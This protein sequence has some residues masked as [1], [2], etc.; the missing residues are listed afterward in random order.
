[1]PPAKKRA[2]SSRP[3][4]PTKAERLQQAKDRRALRWR[5][6]AIVLLVAAL[7]AYLLAN[8]TTPDDRVIAA[9]E[10]SEACEYDTVTD[11]DPP[12]A[13][14][15]E[16]VDPAE[17]G[18]YEPN[19]EAPS[20]LALLR[21]MRQGF[22]VLWYEPERGADDYR[23]VSDRFGRDLVVVPRP[24]LPGAVVVTSWE[25]RLVCERFDEG[26]VVRFTEAF[27]DRGPEKGF[28]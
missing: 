23:G 17:P 21:A 25:R 13:G 9:V 26:A 7:A 24:G 5:L 19:D 1:M 22:V 4:R 6:A 12:A 28:L 15:V 11:E 2:P 18:F 16:D 14:D 20:D 8:R 3:R 10:A 27:R